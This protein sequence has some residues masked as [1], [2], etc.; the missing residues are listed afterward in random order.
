MKEKTI[1]QDLLKLEVNFNQ[2]A[3]I[4][5]RITKKGIEVLL[6]TSLRKGNWIIPKGYVE[7]NLTPFESAKKEAYEEAGVL[8]S[9]ETVEIG[10][11]KRHRSIGNCLIKVFTMEVYDV[12]DDYPEK[13]D[14]QRKW[15]TIQ[16][17]RKVIT[18]PEISEMLKDLS[19]RLDIF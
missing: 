16:E 1:K 14:R 4:P 13:N 12:L 11:F 15:F 3:V 7:F 6:I 19:S 2:S 5:Y 10:T 18:I 17:A 9:N 8:G